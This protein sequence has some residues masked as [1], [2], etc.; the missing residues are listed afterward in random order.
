MG[1]PKAA[2]SNN[3]TQQKDSGSKGGEPKK[4][5]SPAVV[6]MTDSVGETKPKATNPVKIEVLDKPDRGKMNVHQRVLAIMSEIEAVEKTGRNDTQHYNFIEQSTIVALLRKKLVQYGVNIVPSM[7]EHNLTPKMDGTKVKGSKVLAKM[8]FKVVNA[9]DPSDFY[10]VTWWG[11]GDDSL[12]KGTNKAATAAEKYFLMKQFKISD[13]DD[14][15]AEAGS[16]GKAKLPFGLERRDD[17]DPMIDA[18]R[19]VIVRLF[20]KI[21]IPIDGMKDALRN[22]GADPDNMTHKSA[23]TIID[24]LMHADFKAPEPA[25]ALPPEESPADDYGISADEI[26]QS[27]VDMP[28]VGPAPAPEPELELD[29]DLKANIQ[30]LYKKI[31]LNDWGDRWFFKM[32]CSNPFASW[33]RLNEKQWRKAYAV[34]EEILQAAI[35]VPDRYIAGM[36]DP[37]PTLRPGSQAKLPM[38]PSEPLT[39]QEGLTGNDQQT[40]SDTSQEETQ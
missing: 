16:A 25:P 33:D 38:D 17:N 4:P 18:E 11:E 32:V 12:D 5:V 2:E 40:S 26:S 28:V 7:T 1:K 19:S 39:E 24:R 14:P 22:N 31:G 29:D 37:N 6:S 34:V 13:K 27:G 10:E 23:I 21:G 15:D 36:V 30:Q 3:K 9:D 20:N 8:S 35:E